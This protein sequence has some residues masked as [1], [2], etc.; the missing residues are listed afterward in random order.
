MISPL[1]IDSCIIDN[2]KKKPIS[3]SDVNTKYNLLHRKLNM[4]TY[5]FITP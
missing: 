2:I 4:Q 5:D 1:Q 3:P